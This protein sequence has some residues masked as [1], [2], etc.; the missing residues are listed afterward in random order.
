MN[1]PEEPELPRQ[2]GESPTSP[3]GLAVTITS[4]DGLLVAANEKFET[5]PLGPNIA[6]PPSLTDI[7]FDDLPSVE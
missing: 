2:T 6:K 4:S 7:D 5:D 3:E 1:L